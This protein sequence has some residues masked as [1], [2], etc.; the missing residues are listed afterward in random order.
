MSSARRHAESGAAYGAACRLHDVDDVLAYVQSVVTRRAAAFDVADREEL[1]S[2]L[3]VE[4][5]HMSGVRSGRYA[6]EA[7]S[8]PKGVYDPWGT[9]SFSTLL[10]WHLPRRIIDWQRREKG[11]S[12]YQSTRRVIVSLEQPVGNDDGAGGTIGDRIASPIDLVE[13]VHDRERL[14]SALDGAA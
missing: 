3:L 1:T 2:F 5:V 8:V 12:R 6:F 13:H 14:R 9:I 11:D 4:T 10:G 7:G